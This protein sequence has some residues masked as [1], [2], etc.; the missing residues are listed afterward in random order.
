MRVSSSIHIGASFVDCGMNHKGGCI[1]QL[2]G[3]TFKDFALLAD[4]N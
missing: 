3:A 1:E 2:N 4:P